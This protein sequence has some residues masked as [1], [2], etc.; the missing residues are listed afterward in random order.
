MT[1]HTRN[2]FPLVEASLSGGASMADPSA[3]TGTPG[4][5]RRT[6]QAVPIQA[7]TLGDGPASRRMPADFGIAVR[8]GSGSDTARGA[9]EH[10][11]R[12]HSMRG[13]E[14]TYVDIVDYIVRITH[15]IWEDQ[16]VGYIYDTYAPGCFVYDDS[17]P[18]YGVERV[19]ERTMAAVHAFPDTRSWAD[20]V[21]WAGDDE[22]GYVTSYRYITTGYH[23]CAWRWRPATARKV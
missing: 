2:G 6:A 4:T 18:N 1:N 9:R 14:D 13:F 10:G 21:I 19:V 16:D 7:P 17:G 15:R 12:R 22:Q 3:G 23:L 5:D 20:E 8:P 11:E